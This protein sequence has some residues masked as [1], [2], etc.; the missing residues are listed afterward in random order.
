MKLKKADLDVALGGIDFSFNEDHDEKYQGFWCPH[1]HLITSTK[2]KKRLSKKLC[3]LFSKTKEVPH[4]VQIKSFKNSAYG[5]S[6]ALKMN[7]WRRIGYND[8]KNRKGKIRKCRN[9]GRDKLRAA[10]R[11][12]LFVY[13]DKI[14]LAS[15]VIFRGGKPIVTSSRV[16]MVKC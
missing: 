16:K 6:Y 10:E 12:E 9:T 15:R 5:R 14:G 4:P 11:L 1:F 2:N 8:I 7:F 13:R 3:K